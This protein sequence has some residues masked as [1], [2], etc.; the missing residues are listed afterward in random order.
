MLSISS[1]RGSNR[2]RQ[3]RLGCLSAR[4]R[5]WRGRVSR[6][7]QLLRAHRHDRGADDC[8]GGVGFWRRLARLR[9]RLCLGCRAD[10]GASPRPRGADRHRRWPQSR[11]AG[12]ATGRR[13]A[14]PIARLCAVLC[15]DVDPGGG[16]DDGHH[17]SAHRHQWGA[18]L[19]LCR[20]FEGDRADRHIDR[21]PAR[22][23]R[24]NQR[25]RL[26]V[27]RAGDAA[28]R[29]ATH[30]AERRR[31]VDPA[32]LHHTFFRRCFCA[33]F[34]RR[35]RHAVGRKGVSSR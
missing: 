18:E 14:P 9:A 4:V 34:S 35:R 3:A 25:P 23:D 27:C 21:H 15:A 30:D 1:G 33:A 17:L 20:L 6:A 31:V 19:D 32:D 22:R 29:P 11:P 2:W 16:D 12:A 10:L 8:P 26:T 28:R 13:C 5:C 24:D 7:L